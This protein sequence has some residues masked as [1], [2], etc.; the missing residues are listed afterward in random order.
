MLIRRH[1]GNSADRGYAGY[2]LATEGFLTHRFGH[3]SI[4]GTYY[5]HHPP[6]SHIVT[7]LSFKIFGD[8]DF[9]NI[10]PPL[11]FSL[12][13]AFSFYLLAVEIVGRKKATVALFFYTITPV[14]LYYSHINFHENYSVPILTTAIY[15]L[16]KEI[17]SG[18]TKFITFYL[19]L[20]FL[21]TLFSWHV[22]FFYPIGMILAILLKNRTIARHT[23]FGFFLS[24]LGLIISVLV[25]NYTLGYNGFWKLVSESLLFRIGLDGNT[26][27]LLNNPMGVAI[28]LA[29]NVTK[30]VNILVLLLPFVF[31]TFRQVLKE[32]N[33]ATRILVASLAIYPLIPVLLFSNAFVIHEYLFLYLL[34]ATS[35][36]LC[37]IFWRLRIVGR[38]FMITIYILW[39]IFIL[40]NHYKQPVYQKA[41][42]AGTYIRE[43]YPDATTIYC[44]EFLKEDYAES[45]LAYY[46]RKNVLSKQDCEATTSCSYDL[47]IDRDYKIT[48]LTLKT[49]LESVK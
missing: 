46:S 17:R 25:N 22:W 33:Q 43:K 4:N 5:T 16:L 45:I 34:P 23:G 8:S 49:V 6:L 13:G 3:Y 37:V 32:T 10:L 26:A 29:S 47:V 15:L 42:T 41:Y 21:G 36:A 24:T 9:S 14:Y 30:A 39:T 38:I 20:S 35:L 40:E 12:M 27:S 31:I 7:G 28:Y 48:P 18:R 11:T 44:P 1:A 19:L 2:K